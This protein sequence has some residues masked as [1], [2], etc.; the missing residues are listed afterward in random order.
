MPN[1]SISKDRLRGI[2]YTMAVS[3][4]ANLAIAVAKIIYGRLTGSLS[5]YADG[6]HSF[7]DAG[8]SAIG[9]IGVFLAARPPDPSH[10][11]GYERFESLSSLAIVGF[12]VVAII[13]VLSGAADRLGTPLLPHVTWL[14][15]TFM[16]ISIVVSS[17]VSWWEQRRARKFSSEVITA[18]AWRRIGDVLVSIAVIIS[19]IGSYS[20]IRLLDPIVAL[21]VAGVIAWAAFRIIRRASRVLTDAAAVSLEQIVAAS[22]EVPGVVDCHAVR[23]RGPTGSIR[24][25]LHVLVDGNMP[26]FSA[27]NITE[28]VNETVRKIVPGIVEVLVHV[29]PVQKHV[30]KNL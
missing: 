18:D 6:F 3:L 26:V 2:R 1:S 5:M 25:D 19:L 12:M 7:L 23:A 28:Q 22:K 9:L 14:S 8:G 20:G 13:E 16:G 15:Y 27:H 29:G 24:V 17:A 21:V 30:E 10:P 4:A 11:Y